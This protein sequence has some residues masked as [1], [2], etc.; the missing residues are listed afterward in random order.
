MNALHALVPPGLIN[1]R[2]YLVTPHRGGWQWSAYC[3][4]VSRNGQ[5]ASEEAAEALAVQALDELIDEARRKGLRS[6]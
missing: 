3:G 1:T 2:G 5:T 6:V 4:G